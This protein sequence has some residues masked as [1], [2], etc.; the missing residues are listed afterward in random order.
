MRPPQDPVAAAMSTGVFAIVM[1]G[2]A[3]PLAL[4]GRS[5]V[6]FLGGFLI[7]GTLLVIGGIQL[8]QRRASGR[9]L[10]LGGAIGLLAVAGFQFAVALPRAIRKGWDD[11]YWTAIPLAGIIGT[12]VLL[13]LVMR[14]IVNA[15]LIASPP[16]PGYRR[17]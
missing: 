17:F 1:G 13:V 6:L 14:P 11:A 12:V 10:V 5:G 16:P 3:I 2:V 9:S 15:A 7:V 4:F 8:R